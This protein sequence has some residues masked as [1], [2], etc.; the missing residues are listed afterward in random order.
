MSIKIAQYKGKS[1]TSKVIKRVTKGEY[2]HTAIILED[3]RIIEAWQGCNK[4]RVISDLSEGHSPGTPV[5]IYNVSMNS[6]QKKRFTEFVEAQIGKKYDYKGLV[7][8]YFNSGV[9]NEDKWF[10]SELFAAAC[11]YAEA[12]ILHNLLPYQTS[13][14]LASVSPKTHYIKSTVTV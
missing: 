6:A 4:V 8:F 2:S 7:G 5:D 3:G 13:P 14:H 11:I 9:Q 12:Y 10:C 1:F